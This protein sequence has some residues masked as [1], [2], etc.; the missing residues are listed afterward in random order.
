M[1]NYF[2]GKLVQRLSIKTCI[3]IKRNNNLILMKVRIN[4]YIYFLRDFIFKKTL[5]EKLQY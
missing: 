3:Q 2:F 5:F 4:I 1:E